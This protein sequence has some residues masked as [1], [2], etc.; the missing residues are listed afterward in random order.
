MASKK[1]L[2]DKLKELQNDLISFSQKHEEWKSLNDD[3]NPH[4][5]WLK[6]IASDGLKKLPSQISKIKNR[7]GKPP[8]LHY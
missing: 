6:R 5:K 2:E 7:L 4:L 1:Y 3:N 8:V